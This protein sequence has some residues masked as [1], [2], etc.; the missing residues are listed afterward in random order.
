MYLTA[1]LRTCSFTS[2]KSDLPKRS[3]NMYSDVVCM[4][5]KFRAKYFSNK[6][7]H[8]KWQVT[9][10]GIEDR[11]CLRGDFYNS[12]DGMPNVRTESTSYTGIHYV[13]CFVIVTVI[14]L[15]KVENLSL[16]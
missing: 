16:M 4:H 12:D 3:L 5:L 13:Q 6:K 9:N 10:T 15:Q 1:S 2:L 11:N 7:Y 14:V 8:I